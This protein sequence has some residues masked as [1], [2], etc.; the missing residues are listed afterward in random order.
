MSVI[1][2]PAIKTPVRI[3]CFEMCENYLDCVNMNR[4]CRS[5]ITP[6]SQLAN[7][8]GHHPADLDVIS[9][10]TPYFCKKYKT[11]SSESDSNI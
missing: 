1:N 2:E 5:P 3:F 9:I 10:L 7:L 4:K 11:Q 6:H 8:S